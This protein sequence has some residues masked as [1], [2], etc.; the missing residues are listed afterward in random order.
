[1]SNAEINRFAR[2]EKGLFSR[3]REEKLLSI[4]AMGI[5]RVHEHAELLV[6]LLSSPDGD[7]VNA[8]IDAM[9]SIGNPRSVKHLLSF[10]LGEDPQYVERALQALQRFDA[11][12]LLEPIIKVSG[13][14][15]PPALRR[16]LLALIAGVKEAR[17]VAAMNEVLGQTQDG[18]L[19]VEAIGYFVRFP[20][21]DRHTVLKML[22]GNGQWEVAMAA[23]LALSRLGDEGAHSQLKR[24][25]KSPAHP[26]RLAIL[27]GLNRLPMIQD[28]DLYELF[29][30][31]A[32]PQIRAL[33]LEG[34][35]LFNVAER[36]NLFMDLLSKEREEGVRIQ[37]LELA[38]R[39]KALHL[40][41]EFV[42]LLNLPQEKHK[43]L[44]RRAIVDMGPVILDRIISELPKLSLIVK[45]QMLL[46]LGEI[47]TDVVLPVLEEFCVARERWLRLNAIEALARMGAKSYVAKLIE[48]LANEKDVWVLATL[49]SAIA[50]LSTGESAHLFT[51]F[52]D[53]QDARVRANA[54]EGVARLGGSGVKKTLEAHLRDANDRVR[55]NAAIAM[56]RLGDRSVVT[57][58]GAMT[59][60]SLK[61]VRASAAFAL[62]EI[63]D[64]ESVTVLL[65]L[66]ADKEDVVYRNAIDALGKIAD[67]RSL[68]PLLQERQTG[69]LPR[70]EID[71]VLDCFSSHL[72][73]K[74]ATAS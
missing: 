38:A 22:S 23:N 48:L 62:G 50:R 71:R 29:L 73:H 65:E 58:L 10:V 26:I 17:V 63:G 8:V 31:D 34:L 28:R 51:R 6:D 53:H 59:G 16:R 40:Y 69:R 54:I 52:V 1:M 47:G 15:R 2:I 66:L 46:I 45:E 49:L 42:K 19:L 39:E 11:K 12:A 24:L 9:G 44:G 25:A 61:W 60:E 36:C 43:R 70:E 5:L 67:V 41:P 20:A 64:R 57:T 55:V 56:W 33:S 30:R 32:H 18:G 4:A 3:D 35:S 68:I 13:S 37:L 7:V 27:T 21:S 72:M 74:T 14:D